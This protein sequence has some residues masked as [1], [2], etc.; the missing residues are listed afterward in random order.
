MAQ[1]VQRNSKSENAKIA[2]KNNVD[3]ISYIKG[4]IYHKFMPE[5]QTVNGKFYK[6]VIKRPIGRVHRVRP[7]FQE[8]GSWYLLQDNAPAHSS[9]VVSEFLAK[10][11]IPV[12]P[13]PPYSPDLSPA[14]FFI[15]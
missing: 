13:H 7:E 4:V 12:L 1:N 15:S 10:R 9:G 8:S 3:C 6:K 2:D 11:R 5:K 14:Q